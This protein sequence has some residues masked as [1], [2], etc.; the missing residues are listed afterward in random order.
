M[1]SSPLKKF[2]MENLKEALNAGKSPSTSS[3]RFCA[4]HPERVLDFYCASCKSIVCSSC[5]VEEHTLHD[6]KEAARAAVDF[7]QKLE[8]NSARMLAHT[9]LLKSKKLDMERRRKEF[10]TKTTKLEDGI[11]LKSQQL[12]MLIDQHT[13]E[14]LEEIS[15]LKNLHEKK[16]ETEIEEFGKEMETFKSIENLCAELKA[17]GSASEVF[18]F[19]DE[20]I[21]RTEELEIH[22]QEYFH[23]ATTSVELEF[24]D[25]DPG[26]LFSSNLSRVT[27]IANVSNCIGRV[28]ESTKTFG[29]DVIVVGT[30]DGVSVTNDVIRINLRRPEDVSSLQQLPAASQKEAAAVGCCDSVFVVGIGLDKDEIWRYDLTESRWRKCC[31]LVS[32]RRRHSVAVVGRRLFTCAGYSDAVRAS[33]DDVEA[34]D[35]VDD[36]SESVGKLAFSVQNS[37]NCVVLESS[38]YIFGGRIRG[39]QNTDEVQVYDV[40]TDTC[41]LL[42]C[43]MPR[44]CRLMRAALWDSTVILIGQQNCFTYNFETQLW[45]ARDRFKAS[46]GHFGMT[47]ENGQVFVIGGGEWRSDSSGGKAAWIVTDDVRCVPV[48][49]I[50]SDEPVEWRRHARLTTPSL[51]TAVAKVESYAPTIFFR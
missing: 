32:G 44:P 37:G 19:T 35:T 36:K 4:K 8:T 30:N 50:L 3:L 29:S 27:P 10:L 1:A 22:H 43:P 2:S 9:A 12:K 23:R 17:K 15:L 13:R 7:R 46:V 21:R 49:N 38:L 42:S 41:S 24:T 48:L 5:S 34:F 28:T 31:P 6:C 20:L 33:L 16:M 47:L 40:T 39:G 25:S 14:I 45:Q 18:E 26:E 51:V 11:Q